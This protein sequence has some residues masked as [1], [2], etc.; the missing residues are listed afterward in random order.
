MV[1]RLPWGRAAN[2]VKAQLGDLADAYGAAWQAMAG[3]DRMLS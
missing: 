2:L 1:E 3:K